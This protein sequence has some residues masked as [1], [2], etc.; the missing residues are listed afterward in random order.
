MFHKFIIKDLIIILS[1]GER[2]LKIILVYML[3]KEI[4]KRNNIIEGTP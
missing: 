1:N 2:L 3:R 4:E